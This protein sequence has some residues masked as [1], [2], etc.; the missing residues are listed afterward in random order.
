MAVKPVPNGFHTLTPYLIVDGAAKAIDF[1]R[2]AFGATELLSH[3]MPQGD[4]LMHAQVK[5]GDSIVMLADEFPDY[6]ALGPASDR[7]PPVTIHMF[8]EDVAAAFDQAVKA[9]AQV[10]M[11]LEDM[12]WGDRYCIVAD[13]FGHR[14][15]IASRTEALSSEEIMERGKAAFPG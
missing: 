15:S 2:E 3:P 1:Y 12:S 9:G 4:K 8:V 7:N 10:I 14:W 5:I 6:G 13:P 11:P